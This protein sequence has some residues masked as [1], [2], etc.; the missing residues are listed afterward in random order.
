MLVKIIEYSLHDAG[1][2]PLDSQPVC[3]TG[4]LILDKITDQATPEELVRGL[5]GWSG[6]IT[7]TVHTRQVHPL[8]EILNI[9]HNEKQY[10]GV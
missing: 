4:S 8:E 10:Y 9:L 2:H 7:A 5:T 6:P 3:H 1:A